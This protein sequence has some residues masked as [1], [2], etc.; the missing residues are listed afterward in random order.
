MRFKV[1][2]REGEGISLHPSEIKIAVSKLDLPEKIRENRKAHQ[3]VPFNGRD[4]F[5]T[6]EY[7][8]E[9]GQEY[10]EVIAAKR[11]RKKRKR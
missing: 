4:A 8:I 6:F 5:L 9:D 11:A 7:Y 2:I 1:R 10:I 3:T